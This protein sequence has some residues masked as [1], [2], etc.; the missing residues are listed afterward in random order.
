MQR[1]SGDDELDA[2]LF[3]E[4]IM[5]HSVPEKKEAQ[6]QSQYRAPN[7]SAREVEVR[8]GARAALSLGIPLTSHAR[9]LCREVNLLRTDPATFAEMLIRRRKHFYTAADLTS[10]DPPQRNPNLREGKTAVLEAIQFLQNARSVPPL[11]WK[12]RD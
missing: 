8:G 1:H 5:V 4:S 2:L 11:T 12:L 6:P 9:Q 7:L 3:R 10:A